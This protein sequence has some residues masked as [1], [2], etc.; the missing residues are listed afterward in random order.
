MNCRRC[1]FERRFPMV[2]FTLKVLNRTVLTFFTKH[3]SSYIDYCCLDSTYLEVR[4]EGCFDTW[5]D[6]VLYRD[7]CHWTDWSQHTCVKEM[8]TVSR[9]CRVQGLECV[10]REFYIQHCH[11]RALLPLCS[12]TRNSCYPQSSLLNE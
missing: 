4:G 5:Q 11:T 6:A 10:L 7:T 8:M 3:F 2:R 1:C 12:N 9:L